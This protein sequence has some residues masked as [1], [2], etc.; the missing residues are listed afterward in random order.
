MS[1]LITSG[2]RKGRSASERSSAP[3]SSRAMPQPRERSQRDRAEDLGR[4]GAEVALGELDD[5]A[6]LLVEHRLL[7]AED[8]VVAR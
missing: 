8:R 1:S 5:D 2:E 4:A 3:T 7:V 6:D